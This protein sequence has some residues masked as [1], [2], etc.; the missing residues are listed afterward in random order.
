MG[1]DVL[2]NIIT[3]LLMSHVL[4]HV[5]S[6]CIFSQVLCEASAALVKKQGIKLP[7]APDMGCF[8]NAAGGVRMRPQFNS[9]RWYDVK[10]PI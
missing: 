3:C 9:Q 6:H 2:C 5:L 10:A 4:S 7:P 1:E 8:R